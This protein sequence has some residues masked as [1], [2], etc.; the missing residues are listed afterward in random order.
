MDTLQLTK[1]L[2]H[3]LM[4]VMPSWHCEHSLSAFPSIL[5]QTT[6]KNKFKSNS[7]EKAKMIIRKIPKKN[8][9]IS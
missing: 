8:F 9:A 1:I 3:K 4:A 6:I 5:T 2:Q 7:Y